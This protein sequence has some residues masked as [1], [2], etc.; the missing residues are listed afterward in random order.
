MSATD[1]DRPAPESAPGDAAGP[2]PRVRELADGRAMPT[3]GLGLWKIPRGSAADT[4]VG[5]IRAGY[6]HLDGA[7]DYGNEAEVG[8]GIRRAVDEGLCT[9]DELWVTS[10]LWNTYHDPEH[11]APALERS[12]ED[13]GLE[14]LDLYLVH[15]PIALA[16]VPFDVRYPPEWVHDPDADPPRM[17]P[18]RVPLER[19]WHAMEAVRRAGLAGSIGVCNYNTGLLRDC[20][21]YADDPPAVLQVEAH[22]YLC[23]QRLLRYCSEEDVVVTAFSPLGS[24]S[25]VEIGMA[26]EGD[27]VLAE[28]VVVDAARRAGRSPAQVVLRWA[29]QRG[30]SVVAKSTRPE[31]LAENLALFDFALSDE[32]MR[33]ISALDRGRRFNDPGH[34]GEAA[35]NTFMPI[36]D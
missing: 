10:K 35:F 30:T 31:R 8:E 19:T 17:E 34:F 11:V 4:V 24:A 1:P 25:Y 6:R 29:V 12:L 28:P 26:G 32:E 18:V 2:D 5:A 9:R 13:L 22:P 33:G 3:V 15:F 36:Y 27:S 23:Q 21:A 14:S 7:C 16:F 20:L